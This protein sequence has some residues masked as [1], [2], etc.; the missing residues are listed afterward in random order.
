VDCE[1]EHKDA[2]EKAAAVDGGYRIFIAPHSE[3]KPKYD[4][5]M[6]IGRMKFPAPWWVERTGRTEAQVKEAEWRTQHCSNSSYILTKSANWCAVR[7][8]HFVSQGML[9]CPP[10]FTSSSSVGAH[11]RICSLKFFGYPC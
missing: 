7:L 5:Q 10:L 8:P 11:H 3:A 6:L 2:C 1:E 9:T 4:I